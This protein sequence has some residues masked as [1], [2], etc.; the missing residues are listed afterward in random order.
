MAIPIL[1]AV[2]DIIKGPLDKLIPDKNKR[3]EM[4]HEIAMAVN[5]SDHAQMEVNKVEAAHHSIFVAGWR[6]FIGWVCGMALAFEF[7]VRPLTQWALLIAE[8]S[9]V[10][11]VLDT[12][13]L[14]PILMGMLGLGTLRTFEKSKGIAR[15]S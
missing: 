13:A 5:N 4:T 14:Y 9:I 3:A 1:S 15:K 10:L 8:K 11:P 12:N 6:P 2:M 7:L